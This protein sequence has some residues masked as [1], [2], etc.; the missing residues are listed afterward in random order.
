VLYKDCKA[1][2]LGSQGKVPRIGYEIKDRSSGRDFVGIT[3]KGNWIHSDV[4]LAKEWQVKGT[5]TH[6]EGAPFG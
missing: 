5:R 6:R 1:Y 3:K 2:G 4:R